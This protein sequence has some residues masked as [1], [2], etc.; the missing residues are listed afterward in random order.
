MVIDRTNIDEAQRAHWLRLARRAG[1]PCDGTAA[2]WI[3]HDPA[4]CK[5]PPP[6]PPY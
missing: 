3:D 6:L 5:A 2:L 4:L 1:V